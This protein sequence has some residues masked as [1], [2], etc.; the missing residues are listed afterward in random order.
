M[1]KKIL[2]LGAGNAQLDLINYCKSVGIETYGCSYSDKDKGIPLLDHFAQIDIVDVEA[3]KAYFIENQIDYVYSVGSDIAVPVF[4][5]IAEE[6]GKFTFVSSKTAE[7]CCNKHLM[8]TVMRNSKFNVPFKVCSSCE[9]PEAFPVMI[10]PADSQGQRGVYKVNNL[11]EFKRCFE[12]S[13][14]YSKCKKVIVEKY[15]SGNEISVNA[16]VKNGEV[17]F[18]IMSDR[19]SFE[20]LPGGIIKAH[21]LPSE[22]KN[23]PVASKVDELVKEAV[24]KLNINNGPVYFQIMV[25]NEEPY[26]IEV[27]PRLDG[28]HMWKLINEYCSINLFEITMKHF[29]GEDIKT[30][31]F[32]ESKYPMHLEFFSEPPETKFDA[33]KY[34]DYVSDCKFMYY[35]T[36]DTVKRLNGHMEKCGYRIFTSPRKVGVI[37]GSGFIGTAFKSQFGGDFEIKSIS[38]SNKAVSEYS[39]EQIRTALKDCDS[40]VILASKKVNQNEEQSLSLYADNISVAENSLKACKELGIKNIIYASSRCV[41]S[42]KQ[43]VPISENGIIEPINYYGVSKKEAEQLCSFYNEKFGLNVKILR[44]SQV[45]GND[46]NGYMIDK[47]ISNALAGQP[48]S[49][50]GRAEGKRDYIYIKDACKAICAALRSFEAKGVFNIGS[51]VGTSSYELA[52]AIIKSVASSSKIVMYADKPEDTTV[53]YLDVTKAKNVLGFACD[54]SLKDAFKDLIYGGIMGSAG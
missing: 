37:G 36:G 16:Y 10:K 3:V 23:T 15:I 27:T 34:N 33:E 42:N 35:Q 11:A 51:G 29:F 47:F 48:L 8:R 25:S 31:G 7:I 24:S 45:I 14:S 46:K 50:Y 21:H 41:Y 22:Y 19:E 20:N 2:I 32:E 5:R 49:V 4:S 6:T 9:I 17:I 26:L 39:Y 12:D 18:S 52:E 30:E 54:Y 40:V 38:R 28:C 53:T 1:N 13:I 43:S 44:L